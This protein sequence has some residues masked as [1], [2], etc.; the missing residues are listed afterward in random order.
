MKS[1]NEQNS[2]FSYHTLLFYV[3]A[4]KLIYGLEL[5]MARKVFIL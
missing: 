3:Y 4:V 2:P 1:L 5:Y